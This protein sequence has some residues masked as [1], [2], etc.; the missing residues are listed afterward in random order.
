[1][2]NQTKSNELLE[3]SPIANIALASKEL[4]HSNFL[5]WV[6]GQYPMTLNALLEPAGL[7]L[8][9]GNESVRI[10]R[11]EHNLDLVVRIGDER[12]LV[13]ENKLKSVPDSIQL[14]QYKEKAKKVQKGSKLPELILL[15][16]SAKDLIIVS[17]INSRWA[18]VSYLSLSE[19]L[20]KF[21]PATAESYHRLIV[22]DYSQF[23]QVLSRF[24]DSEA[25]KVWDHVYSNQQNTGIPPGKPTTT[26]LKEHKLHDLFGKRQGLVVASQ[27]HKGLLSNLGERLKWQI[28][29]RKLESS[30]VTVYSGFS[31]SHPLVGVFCAMEDLSCPEID[32]PVGVGFQIQGNQFRSYV[33]WPKPGVLAQ[34]PITGSLPS[35]TAAIAWNLFCDS[36]CPENFWSSNR[37]SGPKQQNATGGKPKS[38]FKPQCRFGAEFQYRYTPLRN[39]RATQL[40]AL[41]D[42]IIERANKLVEELPTI[43]RLLQKHQAHYLP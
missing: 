27:V 6:F 23:V 5:A 31:N 2:S 17:S 1:M 14:Q 43:E 12:V 28:P 16:L 18:G 13:V 41:A 19:G 32:I 15:T 7:K 29:P 25:S 33:E 38:R 3:N 30:Q 26:W 34:K 20:A 22:K 4:F 35:R 37:H 11:E 36:E 8:V 21:M 24:A 9:Q 42:Y 10:T 39:G 40:D